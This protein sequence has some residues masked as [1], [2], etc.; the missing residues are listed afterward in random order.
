LDK[1]FTWIALSLLAADFIFDVIFAGLPYQDAPQNLIIMYNRNQNIA[2]WMM[3]IGLA[4]TII[5]GLLQIAQWTTKE[6]E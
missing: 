1:Y 2:N 5:G 6:N 4:M 3:T